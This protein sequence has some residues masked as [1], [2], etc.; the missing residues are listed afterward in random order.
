MH[1]VF[2]LAGLHRTARGAEVVL[3]TVADRIACSGAHEVVV[4]GSG[5]PIAG[6]AYQFSRVGA[7]PR[8]RFERWPNLPFMRDE[9]MLEELT[10][11]SRLWRHPALREA[12]VTVTCGY[13]YTSLALRRANRNG[14]RARHIFVTQNGDWPSQSGRGEARLFHC[15]GLICTNPVYFDRNKERWPTRL[16]PNGIDDHRFSPGASERAIFGLPE[17]RFVV[18]MVSAL[19]DDKRV[20][21]AIEALSF[22]PN[23]HFMLAGD[24]PLRNDVDALGARL[25]PGRF[26]R[27]VFAHR[28][29]PRLFRSANVLLHTT[30]GE[31]FGNIYIE[32]LGC[33]VPVIANDEPSTR[34]ILGDFGTFVD[35][36]NTAA[37]ASAVKQAVLRA[38]PVDPLRVASWAHMR[39]GWDRVAGAYQRFIEEVVAGPVESSSTAF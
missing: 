4:L 10:F 6:R 18:L 38:Q 34:W 28:D 5:E 35:M 33:G 11:A 7:I 20:L 21:E 19:Q 17:D 1:I 9:F 23:L 36:R 25:L 2:A 12:D 39:Y 8:E 29:M 31:P 22:V 13:P 14:V 27:G 37:I 32:A 16:I 15:D 30:I 26:H 24:G 3:E